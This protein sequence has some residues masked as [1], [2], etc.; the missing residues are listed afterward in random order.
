MVGLSMV[1]GTTSDVGRRSG[2]EFARPSRSHS[3]EDDGALSLRLTGISWV[4]LVGLMG[5]NEWLRGRTAGSDGGSCV[6]WGLNCGT[7]PSC[8]GA[9]S[10]EEP[11]VMVGAAAER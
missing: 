3:C 7:V 11:P 8:C 10:A 1:P 2:I 4:P 5:V 9:F 6:G